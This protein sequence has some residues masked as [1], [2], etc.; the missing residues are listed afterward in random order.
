MNLK[1][2]PGA[3]V[4]FGQIRILFFLTVLTI[5][6]YGWRHKKQESVYV[7]ICINIYILKYI[8]TACLLY[9]KFLLCMFQG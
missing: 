6:S 1:E 4:K 9:L 7:C 8:N 3:Q 5:H 2:S